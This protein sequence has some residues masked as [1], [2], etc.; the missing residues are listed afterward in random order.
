MDIAPAIKRMDSMMIESNI[1]KMGR[2][3]LLYTCLA[4]LVHKIARDGQSELLEG[5]H[6][7][8][9][10]NHRNRVVYHDQSAP[11]DEKIQKIIN[12][13][14]ALLPNCKEEY[15]QTDEYQLLQRA[16]DE[17]TKHDDKG[18]RIPKTKDDRMA[19]DILQN[20][21][22]PEATYRSKAGKSHKG[23]SANFVEPV[24]KKG[25][26]IVDYQYDVNTKSD[27]SSKNTW[28]LRKFQKIL[29]SSLQMVHMPV[30]KLP[31]RQLIRMSDFLPQ[32]FLAANPKRY[33]GS[34]NLMKPGI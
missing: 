33:G 12:D 8:E 21:S 25:S 9:D 15:S 28:N 10:A 24:D 7:Y 6:D 2:L 4:N 3:E 17:Q 18:N 13:A 32:D 29:L 5:L 1:G 22:D 14:A 23:Y 27:A 30:K 31:K 11:Q 34:L 19:S 16:I 20:P 26:V